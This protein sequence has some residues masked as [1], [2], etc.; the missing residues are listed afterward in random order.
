MVAERMARIVARMGSAGASASRPG[1]L[2]QIAADITKVSGAGVMVLADGIPQASLCTTGGIAALI[3]ELQIT[4]GEGPCIDAHAMGVAVA[5]PDLAA[6]VV[7]RWPAFSPK[8]VDAGA[9]AVFGFPVRIGVARIGALNLYRDEPGQLSDDQHADALVVADVL[10]RVLLAIEADVPP[11]FVPAQLNTEL[12]SVVHQA[13]GMVS[14]QLH[15]SVGEALVR[16]RA[17]AFGTDR[18]LVE[19]ARD[20]INRQLYFDDS[21]ES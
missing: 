19:V 18:P 13:A 11:G 5:E 16:L 4:F 17:H 9:R 7:P 8:V 1:P 3:E 21:N 10:A 15:V 12:Q 6:P 20:V 2:C 14:I